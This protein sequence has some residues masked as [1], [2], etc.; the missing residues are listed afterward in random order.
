[1]PNAHEEEKE[2]LRRLVVR[3]T[4]L[5]ENHRELHFWEDVFEE[6]DAHD[7]ADLLKNLENE[8]NRMSPG[9]PDNE[10]AGSR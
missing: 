7:R 1:M 5:G 4:T 2:R 9:Q 10:G 6:L 3:L 8:L